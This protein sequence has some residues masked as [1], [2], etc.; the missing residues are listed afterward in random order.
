M[1][2]AACIQV[3][4]VSK[5]NLFSVSRGKWRTSSDIGT[6]L[7]ETQFFTH[8]CSVQ[9]S[10]SYGFTTYSLPCTK[11][12]HFKHR[13]NAR[14]L[15]PLQRSCNGRMFP[16][17]PLKRTLACQCTERMA[18]MYSSQSMP[19]SSSVIWS[20]SLSLSVPQFLLCIMGIVALPYLKEVRWGARPVSTH[21]RQTHLGCSIEVSIMEREKKTPSTMSAHTYTH[22]YLYDLIQSLLEASESQRKDFYSF[23][24]SLGQTHRDGKIP[25]HGW[26]AQGGKPVAVSLC[27]Q[28]DH[29][30]GSAQ[31]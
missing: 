6:W 23:Q 4:K 28:R 27:P 13:L 20:K 12:A 14:K 3:W 26:R 16:C 31:E 1:S 25:A 8:S 18:Q 15:I 11:F 21:L 2:T 17:K 30:P 29:S 24:W 10:A 5:R 22:P 9:D 19:L 7:G